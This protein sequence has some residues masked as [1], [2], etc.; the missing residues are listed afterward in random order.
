MRIVWIKQ[1]LAYLPSG[2]TFF[3]N[4]GICIATNENNRWH[5]MNAENVWF[6][7]NKQNISCHD[8]GDLYQAEY[9]VK[10]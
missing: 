6:D 5:V 8:D 4:S 9:E 7:H 10:A 2:V 3:F 1:L